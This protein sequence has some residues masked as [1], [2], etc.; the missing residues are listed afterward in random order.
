MYKTLDHIEDHGSKW[1]IC[2]TAKLPLVIRRSNGKPTLCSYKPYVKRIFQQA[3]WLV[4]WNMN[5]I[6]PYIGN[7]IIPTD[8]HIFQRYTTNQIKKGFSS[9]PCLITRG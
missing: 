6:F 2:Q 8:F 3:I 9:K 4:V 7:F 5:F 1:V